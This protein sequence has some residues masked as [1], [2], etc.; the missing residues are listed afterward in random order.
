MIPTR[1]ILCTSLLLA[2]AF[3]AMGQANEA[4]VQSQLLTEPMWTLQP[5][6]GPG[7]TVW[8]EEMDG[9][10][11]MVLCKAIRP[12]CRI[13]VR[14][15]P[16]D[17][18]IGGADGLRLTLTTAGVPIFSGPAVSLFPSWVVPSSQSRTGP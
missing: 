7:A 8:F 12:E 13:H 6:D 16:Q 2:A 17:L 11:Q 14:I 9:Q 10:V 3:P 5:V 1:Q 15:A 4:T 18:F